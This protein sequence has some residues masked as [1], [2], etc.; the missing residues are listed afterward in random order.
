MLKGESAFTALVRAGKV[1]PHILITSGEWEQSEGCPTLHSPGRQEAL[2]H[3][4]EDRMVDNARYLATRLKSLKGSSSYEVRY[5]L[6]PEETHV[7][8]MAAATSRGVTFVAAPVLEK[9]TA[10]H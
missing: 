9:A 5:T 4:R 2:A 3:M 6:F 1:A 8:G 7:S 10:A